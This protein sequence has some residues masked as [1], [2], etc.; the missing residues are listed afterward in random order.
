M[1]IEIYWLLIFIS[2]TFI[3]LGSIRAN[4]SATALTG[5]GIL[6]LLGVS[7]FSYGIEYQSGTFTNGTEAKSKTVDDAYNI[8]IRTSD[9][10]LFTSVNTSDTHQIGILLCAISL[11]GFAIVFVSMKNNRYS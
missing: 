3:V 6:F 7:M 2:L 4:E 5:Y 10:Y 8:T 9:N 11:I 1:I